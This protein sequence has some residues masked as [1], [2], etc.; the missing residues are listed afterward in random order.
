MATSG[1]TIS[2]IASALLLQRALHRFELLIHLVAVGERSE[3]VVE[4]A[5]AQHLALVFGHAQRIGAALGHVDA[6]LEQVEA[7]E[8]LADLVAIVHGAQ[9]GD[10]SLIGMGAILMNGCV[11]GKDCIIG[12]G[13]LVT[14]N[15]QIPDGSLVIG[16]PAKVVRQVTEEERRHFRQNAESYITEA[17][18]YRE[19]PPQ[20]YRMK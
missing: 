4:A 20:L 17:K 13:A 12:A 1:T 7:A 15:M 8:C 18:E 3:F 16:S 14:Q 9:I 5:L 11:I 19:N 10:N 2:S 6:A